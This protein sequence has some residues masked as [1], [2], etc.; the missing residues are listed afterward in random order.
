MIGRD[1]PG[2]PQVILLKM[3]LLPLDPSCF[4]AS[5]FP[6]CTLLQNP[7]SLLRLAFSS[8]LVVCKGSFC[9]LL[10]LCDNICP[11]GSSLDRLQPSSESDFQHPATCPHLGVLRALH[12]PRVQPKLVLCVPVR[13]VICSPTWLS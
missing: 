1:G 11:Q 7:S 5:F 4:M 2:F 13:S 3:L 8:V 9:C 12:I 10:S 6:Q